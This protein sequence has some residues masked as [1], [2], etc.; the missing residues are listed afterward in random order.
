M[1][2][3]CDRMGTAQNLKEAALGYLNQQ[4]PIDRSAL[5]KK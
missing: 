2:Q 4:N 1:L 5:E 3:L